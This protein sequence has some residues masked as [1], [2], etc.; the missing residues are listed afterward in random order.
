MSVG[1][2][3]PSEDYAYSSNPIL[4]VVAIPLRLFN[5]LANFFRLAGWRDGFSYAVLFGTI[6]DVHASFLI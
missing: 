6:S 5:A 1:L 3:T 2:I 4:R